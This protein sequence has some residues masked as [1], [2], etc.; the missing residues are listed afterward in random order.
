MFERDDRRAPPE[1]AAAPSARG[2]R[3]ASGRETMQQNQPGQRTQIVR[4]ARARFSV[5]TPIPVALVAAAADPALL[6]QLVRLRVPDLQPPALRLQGR[7]PAPRR[8]FR[9]SSSP[10]AR[11]RRD[12]RPL[13][14]SFFYYPK[15]FIW[16]EVS[17]QI[18]LAL[19]QWSRIFLG[20]PRRASK[21]ICA[22]ARADGPTDRR[23]PPQPPSRTRRRC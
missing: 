1:S 13:A 19:L 22:R 8:E 15:Y 9:E 18:C 4:F 14:G 5:R 10:R 17:V 23:K 11:L 20:A 21:C 3:P 16:L 2:R 6:R 12:A 7:A